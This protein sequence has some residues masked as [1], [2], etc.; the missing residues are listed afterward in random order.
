MGTHKPLTGQEQQWKRN[1]H[2]E[3]KEKRLI[4]R[5]KKLHHKCFI[6]RSSP[7]SFHLKCHPLCRHGR[8][9]K[10]SLRSVLYFD[11]LRGCPLCRLCC[12]PVDRAADH[13]R[14]LVG[15]CPCRGVQHNRVPPFHLA[16]ESSF[17]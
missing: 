13:V 1:R 2:I 10:R 12:Y 3:I 14:H 16:R 11:D 5:K 9:S 15:K 6:W 7:R 4:L 17:L 8:V